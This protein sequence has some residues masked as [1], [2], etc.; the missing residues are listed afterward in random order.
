MLNNKRIEGRECGN[1]TA[2]C[3]IPSIAELDKPVRTDCKFLLQPPT[4]HSEDLKSGL[5]ILNQFE[6]REKGC[7]IYE[8]RPQTCRNFQCLWLTG[9]WGREEDR[10]D[11][12]GIMPVYTQQDIIFFWEV[13][14]GAAD[15]WYFKKIL[16]RLAKTLVFTIERFNGTRDLIGSRSNI[17]CFFKRGSAPDFFKG[18]KKS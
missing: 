10:P 15:T 4:A 8:N 18:S 11:R 7:A 13:W 12:L 2:C 16:N 6:G 17:V 3:T 14:E 5:L 9:D 1:C